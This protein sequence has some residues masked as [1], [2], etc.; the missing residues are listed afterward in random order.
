MIVVTYDDTL[1]RVC[2]SG[3]G[4]QDCAESVLVERGLN[5]VRMD[6]V[7][8][9]TE[10]PIVS[11]SFELC[12]YEFFADRTNYYRV[13]PQNFSDTFDGDVSCWESF[14]VTGTSTFTHSSAAYRSCC[15]SGLITPDGT[16]TCVG[17]RTTPYNLLPAEE[18]VDHTLAVWLMSPNVSGTGDVS[19]SVEFFDGVG[20]SLGT[21]TV[22]GPIT[23]PAGVWTYMEGV[24]T[25]PT[26]TASARIAVNVC[27][28]PTASDLVYVDDVTFTPV[29]FTAVTG[30]IAP[31]LND[32]VWLKSIR[33]PFLNRPVRVSTWSDV[34]RSARSSLFPVSGRSVPVAVS[35]VRGSQQFTLELVVD[36]LEGERDMDLILAAGG[37]MF[38]HVPQTIVTGSACPDF[39]VNSRVPGGYVEIGDVTDSRHVRSGKM[40]CR[41]F[42]LPMT[43]VA[44]PGPD[45]CGGTMTWGAVL[46]LFA[47]WQNLVNANPTWIDLLSQVAGPDDL[48]AL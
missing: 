39:T 48:V 14:P 37:P 24:V 33:W 19:I 44:A 26:N 42:S 7:R 18:D 31:S 32:T 47:D 1:S 29:T 35:D 4:M 46:N 36:T 11:G 34:N 12:D 27:G 30:S 15:G 23:L 41:Y 16:E 17:A 20:T 3:A 25:S 8:C 43:V 10:V 22:D 40:P 5:L 21:T 45:V 28:T 9:G 38:V 2:V 6:T 13:T